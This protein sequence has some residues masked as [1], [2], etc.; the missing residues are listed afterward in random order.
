VNG[1]EHL[2]NSPFI[3]TP[4][5]QSYLDAMIISQCFDANLLRKTYF[6]A[7]ERHFRKF[8]QR[9]FA[10]HHN[11]IIVDINRE[12]KLSLQKMAEVLRK[13]NNM[14]LFPEGART[15]MASWR[16]SKKPLLF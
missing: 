13:K 7:E 12:L 6:Y 2:K 4:N 3:L 10:D 15:A 11:V 14:V 16:S 5:H 9:L 8:W 1:L